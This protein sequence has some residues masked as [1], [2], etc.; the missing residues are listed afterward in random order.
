M[1]PK[2]CVDSCTLSTCRT[3]GHLLW[4]LTASPALWALRL[5]GSLLCFPH[6]LQVVPG[7]EVT[8]ELGLCWLM[9]C[10]HWRWGKRGSHQGCGLSAAFASGCELG[11]PD[12][13]GG[14][15]AGAAQ[16]ISQPETQPHVD[17]RSQGCSLSFPSHCPDC[18]SSN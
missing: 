8:G 11:S 6:S 4:A 13:E 1:C 9:E 12:A 16:D 15:P 10:V 14:R 7:S 5:A 3:K 18:S 17:L 2:V